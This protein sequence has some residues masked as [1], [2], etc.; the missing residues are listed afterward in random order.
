MHRKCLAPGL[1]LAVARM[2]CVGSIG[3]DGHQVPRGLPGE[4]PFISSTPTGWWNPCAGNPSPITG[5]RGRVPWHVP[6][7][8]FE[9]S[10]RGDWHMEEL[11]VWP[12]SPGSSREALRLPRASGTGS[13]SRAIPGSRSQGSL[14]LWAR[15]QPLCRPIPPASSLPRSDGG[16]RWQVASSTCLTGRAR[17]G[18]VPGTRCLSQPAGVLP[19]VT[20]CRGRR[21][22]TPSPSATVQG[23]LCPTTEGN[24]E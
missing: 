5:L 21:S 8:F 4:K 17:V 19:R 13:P 2:F 22:G 18:A 14:Y 6:Q 7:R 20:C 3:A 16:R 12:L 23:Q 1:L 9:H 15:P 10:R 24:Q 11:I